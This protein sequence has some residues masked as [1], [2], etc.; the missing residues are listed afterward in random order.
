MK[1][2]YKKEDFTSLDIRQLF[3]DHQ[4]EYHKAGEKNVTSGWIN[5]NCP[6]CFDPSWHCGINLKTKIFNCYICGKKGSPEYLLKFILNLSSSKIKRIIKKYSDEIELE[7]EKGIILPPKEVF[8]PKEIEKN[9]PKLH[10]NYLIK[11]RFDLSIIDKYNLKA[12]Y[13]FGKYAYRIIIPFYYQN[14]LVTF[15]SRDVTEKSGLRYL[16]LNSE[17]S[18]FKATDTLYNI[19]SVIDKSVII[20]EGCTDVWR[21]G[22][23]CVALNT[24]SISNHQIKMLLSKKINKVIVMLD[25]GQQ[26]RAE[27]ITAKL[28]LFMNVYLVSLNEEDPAEMDQKQVKEIRRKL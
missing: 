15:T 18:I 5:I 27:E 13:Q 28:S 19:D 8:L 20:V 1:K 26:A 4:I 10:K 25:N 9:F 11:R 22:D 16:N 3:D 23:H 12:C 17:D 24:T 6:F 21:I 7:T 14:K 2:K